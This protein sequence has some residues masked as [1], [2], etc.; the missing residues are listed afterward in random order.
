MRLHAVSAA[1]LAAAVITAPTALGQ[2]NSDWRI[3]VDNAAYSGGVAW[4]GSQGARV[5]YTRPSWAGTTYFYGDFG[6]SSGWFTMTGDVTRTFS[7]LAQRAY[8][9]TVLI[10]TVPRYSGSM[11]SYAQSTNTT[12]FSV[13]LT[14]PGAPGVQDAGEVAR[15]SLPVR[16][17][18]VGDAHSGVARY[19]VLVDGV[20]RAEVGPGHCASACEALLPSTALQ[21]GSRLVEVVAWDHVGNSA[22]G[23][24]WWVVR[25]MPR[26]RFDDA[27][28]SVVRGEQVT[29]RA[30]GE[31]DNQGALSYAWD[32]DGD[33]EFEVDTA[34]DPTTTIT[35]QAGVVLRV[36]ATAP[37]GG[38]AT[39]EH[40]LAVH[41]RPPAADSATGEVTADREPGVTIEGGRRFVRTARVQLGIAWPAGT[42]HMLIA[43]DGGF[44]GATWQPVA[45][46]AQVTLDSDDGVEDRM[47][48]VV[49]VRFRGAGVDPRATYTDDVI[50]D[51][52]PPVL[53]SATARATAQGTRIV[54]RARDGLSGVARVQ[55]RHAGK[56]EKRKIAT[57]RYGRM[58]VV[59]RAGSRPMVR[60][61][62][63]AGNP[64]RWVRAR[65]V[66][67]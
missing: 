14:P 24:S 66:R 58:V 36:R 40:A 48:H 17:T 2:Q 38:Q 62:D 49:Y 53:S 9:M 21:D 29:V 45:E 46:R 60:V 19:E 6:W 8:V 4:V 7:G 47:P 10:R 3:T 52:T 50:I 5:T 44:A 42:T 31:V 16:W 61:V 32:L 28:A 51:T 20:A 43:T 30:A 27:P 35:A 23:A 56:S 25:D 18:P 67:G 37:G 63:R 26:V 11:V 41:P 55:V 33:G 64:S 15:S 59:R 22:R 13:D 34:A 65:P 57:A 39:A 54:A 12:R 1:A